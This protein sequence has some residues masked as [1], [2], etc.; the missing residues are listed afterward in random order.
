MRTL[1][2]AA[3]A[4]LSALGG[5]SSTS[6]NRDA[7]VR[8]PATCVDQT[9][10]VYFDPWSAELTP[11][12]RAVIQT[13]AANLHSCRI[14][15]V[16]VLGLADAQGDPQANLELSKRRASSVSAAL[17]AAG[18]PAAEFQLAAAGEAGAVTADGKAAPVRRRVD[19]TLKVER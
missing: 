12:G 11:E 9:V 2:I 13:A 15:A 17:A 18:L 7:L 6:R 1:T 5:C 16:E 8:A 3:L 19:V 4:G 14:R 10:Q